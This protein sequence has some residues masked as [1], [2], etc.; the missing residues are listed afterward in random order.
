MRKYIEL[1]VVLGLAALFIGGL[2]F[3]TTDNASPELL[4]YMK[5]LKPEDITLIDYHTSTKGYPLN[6]DKIWDSSQKL[7]HILQGLHEFQINGPVALFGINYHIQKN[8]ESIVLLDHFSRMNGGLI[9]YMRLSEIKGITT[10]RAHFFTSP[11]LTDWLNT[12]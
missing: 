7:C 5:S 11:E 8:G 12:L 2:L 1:L 4:K 9:G 10:R 3:F 6:E